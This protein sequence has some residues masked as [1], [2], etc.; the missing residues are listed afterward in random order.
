MMRI[1]KIFILLTIVA[2]CEK[3][4]PMSG[5]LIIEG[6][7]YANSHLDL[8][9][10]A[11]AISTA[12]F[13]RPATGCNLVLETDGKKYQLTDKQDCPGIYYYPGNDLIIK[14]G[15]IYI[16]TV[17]Y[18]EY[19]LTA[20]TSIPD[21]SS[22]PVL[23]N[24][25]ILIIKTLNATNISKS[26]AILSWNPETNYSLI[27]KQYINK[28]MVII[29]N[30]SFNKGNYEPYY[31]MQPLR[32]N[33]IEMRVSDFRYKG[34]YEIYIN[35]INDD[36]KTLFEE[37]NAEG[38]FTSGYAKENITGGYG[39]FTGVYCDTVKIEVTDEQ[40]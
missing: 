35:Q 29:E 14:S 40:Q 39:I 10:V 2:G 20:H 22:H 7:L 26:S 30:P 37:P 18:G 21:A 8:I 11:E 17:I 5:K 27:A 32:G 13:S 4:A 12:A 23:S 6:Y 15:H 25:T 36:Y 28:N 19:K 31:F 16:L 3:E 24:D 9:R 33:V 1:L 34:S 38:T